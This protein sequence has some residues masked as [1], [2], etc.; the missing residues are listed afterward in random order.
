MSKRKAK[1]KLPT[2]R[3]GEPIHIGDVL[4]WDYGDFI[5]VESLTYYGDEF[6]ALGFRWVANIE[7][8]DKYADNLSGGEIVWR[9][10]S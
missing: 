4:V 6:D 5:K 10:K 2:D 3:N 8:D 1:V 9:S 7:S